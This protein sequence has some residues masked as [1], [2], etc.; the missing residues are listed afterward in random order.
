MEEQ[1]VCIHVVQE[2]RPKEVKIPVGD[3]RFNQPI[4]IYN[5]SE[6]ETGIFQQLLV[7]RIGGV[8]A[9]FAAPNEIALAL[10]ASRN[11]FLRVKNQ[12][13][14]I[15]ALAKQKGAIQGDDATP[16]YDALED[17]QICVIFSYKAV[18]SLCNALIPDDFVH[19]VEDS[20]GII[21]RYGKEQIERWIST[22]TKVKEILPKVIGCPKPSEQKFWSDFK[23]LENLRNDIVHSKSKSSAETL[24]ELFSDDLAKYLRSV[25]DLI[26][27]FYTHS[28]T[29]QKFP[30]AF[31]NMH[32]SVIE[33]DNFEDL[34]QQID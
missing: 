9:A 7:T 32:I 12:R 14:R 30:V 16:F 10:G 25:S 21:Q 20:K 1:F 31:G 24:S 6:N 15:V 5:K 33:I 29:R 11:A 23:S 22:S 17:L 8:E 27:F 2:G 34:L 19:E 4:A 13:D 26:E 3:H 18:E 28:T